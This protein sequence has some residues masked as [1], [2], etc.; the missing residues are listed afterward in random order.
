MSA[1]LSM[2]I[3]L[4]PALLLLLALVGGRYPGERVLERL[5]ARRPAP[6]RGRAAPAPRW[7]RRARRRSG[8][9]LARALAGRGPPGS[10]A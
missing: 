3:A 9:L 2:L 4:L 8:E 7:T 10:L 5:R 6:S 1:A